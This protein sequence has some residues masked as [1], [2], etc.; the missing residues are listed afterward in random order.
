MFISYGTGLPILYTR[1]T[2]HFYC[3]DETPFQGIYISSLFWLMFFT[4]TFKLRFTWL[5]VLILVSVDFTLL[6]KYTIFE[7]LV[8][9]LVFQCLC[10]ILHVKIVSPSGTGNNSFNLLS[11]QIYELFEKWYMYS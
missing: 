11:K 1:S 8:E 9:L 2:I 3:D 10:C 4:F 5:L 7:H 6:F